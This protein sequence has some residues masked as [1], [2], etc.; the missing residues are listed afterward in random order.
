[1]EIDFQIDYS[2]FEFLREF[3]RDFWYSPGSMAEFL[4]QA[5]EDRKQGN[6][7]WYV[8]ALYQETYNEIIKFFKEEVEKSKYF[9]IDFPYLSNTEIIRFRDIREKWA[10]GEYFD[11]AELTT[12]ILEEKF[13]TFLY[14]IFALLYGKRENRL[15]R[16]DASSRMYIR[17]NM[18]KERSRGFK[19]ARNEFEQ[20]N[21]G[22]YKNFMVGSFD[23]NIGKKNWVN[24]FSN[25]F[26]PLTENEVQKFLSAF[27]EINTVVSHRKNHALSSENQALLLNYVLTSFDLLKKMNKSYNIL[28][29]NGFFVEEK[30]NH[31]EFRFSFNDLEDKNELE[32]IIVG[33]NN[34]KRV[35]DALK[36]QRNKYVI[37]L[38][39][40]E[41]LEAYFHIAYREFFAILAR[42]LNQSEQEIK[43][44]GLSVK[45]NRSK[46]SS[47]TLSLIKSE[48]ADFEKSEG[49]SIRWK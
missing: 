31:V 21:R 42:L 26:S 41:N 5:E 18:E 8:C 35:I 37:D 24:I 28:L 33:R 34:A 11:V 39:A 1:M 49:E 15:I 32:P 27:A 38:E 25:I 40:R 44:T 10:E 3:W 23:R 46:G 13:R 48:G 16:I 14:N 7:T 4:N 2:E 20:L 30:D 19:V 9:M 12:Q 29:D 47:V 36:R 45:I 6:K 22:N 17:N 43:Q